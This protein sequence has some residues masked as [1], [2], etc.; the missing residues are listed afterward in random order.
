MMIQASPILGRQRQ[1]FKVILCFIARKE[2]EKEE[3]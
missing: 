2:E 3:E 1:E